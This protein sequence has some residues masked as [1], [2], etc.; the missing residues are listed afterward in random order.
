MPEDAPVIKTVSFMMLA[1]KM[2]AFGPQWH[3]RLAREFL[4]LKSSS[5]HTGGTA[6]PL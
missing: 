4:N 3:G 6:V 5:E 2:I 1:P